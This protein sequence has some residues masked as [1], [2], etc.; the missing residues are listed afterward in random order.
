LKPQIPVDEKLHT[1]AIKTQDV[2][3]VASALAFLY[4]NHDAAGIPKEHAETVRELFEF[5]KRIYESEVP[6]AKL[7]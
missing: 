3:F 5:F 7:P 2:G 4:T 1:F 6:K